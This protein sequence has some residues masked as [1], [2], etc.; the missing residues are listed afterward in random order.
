MLKKFFPLIAGVLTCGVAFSFAYLFS[1]NGE[2]PSSRVKTTAASSVLDIEPAPAP[3]TRNVKLFTNTN[4]ANWNESEEANAIA[5]NPYTVESL[6]NSSA[7]ELMNATFEDLEEYRTQ[8]RLDYLASTVKTESTDSE[9]EAELQDRI[10]QRDSIVTNPY[11]E[12]K[13]H[14]D[15]ELTAKDRQ[16]NSAGLRQIYLENTTGFDDLPPN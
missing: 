6:A 13:N 9:Q 3:F 2:R 1:S 10:D 16:L 4:K 5:S 8:Q 12:L 7:A 14:P 11:L 15:A